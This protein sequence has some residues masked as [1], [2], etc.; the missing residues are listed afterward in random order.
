M[1]ALHTK[2]KKLPPSSF[3]K[4]PKSEN[5]CNNNFQLVELFNGLEKNRAGGMYGYFVTN[6]QKEFFGEFITRNKF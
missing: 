2:R 6:L 3:A 1:H 5:V 4:N